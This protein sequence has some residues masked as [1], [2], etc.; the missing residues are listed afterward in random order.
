M[1]VEMPVEKPTKDENMADIDIPSNVIEES[2]TGIE[3][4]DMIRLGKPMGTIGKFTV[5]KCPTRFVRGTQAITDI[6]V[7]TDMLDEFDTTDTRN[8]RRT[9]NIFLLYP[10][11]HDNFKEVF[12]QLQSRISTDTAVC[13]GSV[14][15]AGVMVYIRKK[16]ADYKQ[17]QSFD[18]DGLGPPHAFRFKR[19]GNV[20]KH[21]NEVMTTFSKVIGDTMTNLAIRLPPSGE[22]SFEQFMTGIKMLTSEQ[23][24]T[25]KGNVE[26]KPPKERSEFD[27]AF[28]R[29]LPTLQGVKDLR[30][31]RTQGLVFSVDSPPFPV[32]PLSHLINLEQQGR[33][34]MERTAGACE[35]VSLMD[36]F[37][38]ATIMTKYAVLILGKSSTTGYGKTQLA[39]RLAMEWAA[40]MTDAAQ[41]P[42]EE[43]QVVFTNTV[44]AAKNVKF[45]QGMVWV[46]D[47]FTPC[48]HDQVVHCSENMLKILFSPSTASTPRGRNN[49]MEI[50][51]GVARI[52]TANADSPQ[53]WCGDKI[54]WS[55][56]LR[57][58][59]VTFSITQP[60]CKEGW[61]N[62]EEAVSPIDAIV[63]VASAS[64]AKRMR[65][66]GV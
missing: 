12:E 7:L 46:L 62:S 63:E 61:W 58:K 49:D 5:Q 29:A 39:L 53:A 1:S 54:E 34:L 6:N 10:G 27:K 11:R 18:I 14:A 8:A 22:F 37:E 25:L 21:Y 42:K 45:K 2:M 59:S 55:E 41:L 44:D 9:M 33:R 57:R 32:I 17:L 24:L 35:V 38:N 13:T 4:L 56:P 65:A 50:C 3:E 48:D 30:R 60:L 19:S 43:A 16:A 15:N 23:I 47:E 31:K 40:A 66:A 64:M 36:L 28:L 20:T 52:I 51:P 26:V